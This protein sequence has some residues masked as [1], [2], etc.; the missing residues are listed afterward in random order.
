MAMNRV[1]IWRILCCLIPASLAVMGSTCSSTNRQQA[2]L[3]AG[4]WSTQAV[5]ADAN[6]N[7]ATSFAGGEHIRFE[8]RLQSTSDMNQMIKTILP[9]E[10]NFI[11]VAKGSSTIG[12]DYDQDADVAWPAL[13]G[14]NSYGFSPGQVRE[15]T[16]DWD[17][18]AQGGQAIAP[19]TYEVQARVMTPND[20]AAYADLRPSPYRSKLVEF[21]IQP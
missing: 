5:V 12:F 4:V 10:V 13:T 14:Y 9:Y 20:T 11:V 6:G 19:G 2:G 16:D 15:F 21:T 1:K 8:L 7:P 3:P 18:L 17:Q